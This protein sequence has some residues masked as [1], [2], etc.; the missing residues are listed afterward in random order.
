MC[1]QNNLFAFICVLWSDYGTA[2]LKYVILIAAFQFVQIKVCI[3]V[4]IRD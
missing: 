4:D 3:E 1:C 2:M